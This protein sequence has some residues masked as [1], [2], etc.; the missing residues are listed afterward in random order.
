MTSGSGLELFGQ[1]QFRNVWS[2][3]LIFN[4]GT[5]ILSLAAAWTMTS[6]TDNPVLV[7]MVQTMASLPFVL[8]AI[9]LGVATDAMGHRTMMIASQIWMLVV[10]ALL[11]YVA[12]PG[13]IELTPKWLLAVVFLVGIGVLTAVLILLLVVF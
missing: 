3:N 8:F 5:A 2:A 11:G 7:S 1:S 9:P 6:L 12:L 10:T 4:L 13:T